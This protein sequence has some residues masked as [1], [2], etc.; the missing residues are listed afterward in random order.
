MDA[1]KDLQMADRWAKLTAVSMGEM[2]AGHWAAETAV[3]KAARMD[4]SL[5]HQ[6]AAWTVALLALWT[7]A[8]MER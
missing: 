2:S 5:E 3:S 8:E 7:V 6:T 1:S 4:A